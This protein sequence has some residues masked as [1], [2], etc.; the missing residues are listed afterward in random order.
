[1]VQVSALTV[2]NAEKDRANAINFATA[3]SAPARHFEGS[4]Y[5][6]VDGHVKWLKT[7]P[8][9]TDATGN[10][11][12]FFVPQT[13]SQIAANTVTLT[14]LPSN[15]VFDNAG[16]SY[17]K[18]AGNSWSGPIGGDGNSAGTGWRL[19][20]NPDQTNYRASVF[21]YGDRPPA[22]VT[23]TFT[24]GG[25][26]PR[27]FS[28]GNF[29][30]DEERG[31]TGYHSAGKFVMSNFGPGFDAASCTPEGLVLKMTSSGVEPPVTYSKTYFFKRHNYNSNTC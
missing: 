20:I 30:E 6:F 31:T 2:L 26:P 22:G 14:S 9:A 19:Q 4:N 12:T 27:S 10:V 13:S 23:Y 7:I 5:A 18:D 15:F 29:T 3:P 8:S 1:M 24:L 25:G 21:I 11:S 16:Y 17:G 28:V